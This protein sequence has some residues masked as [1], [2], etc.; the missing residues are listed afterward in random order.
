MSDVTH[1]EKPHLCLNLSMQ[2]AAAKGT[3]KVFLPKMLKGKH[4]RPHISRALSISEQKGA[5][6]HASSLVTLNY[7]ALTSTG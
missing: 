1:T 6:V 7:K 4:T 2:G 3:G 5:T